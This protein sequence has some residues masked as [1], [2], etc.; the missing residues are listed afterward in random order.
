MD[1]IHAGA[2]AWQVPPTSREGRPLVRGAQAMGVVSFVE[3]F[4]RSVCSIILFSRDLL[5]LV[6]SKLY[7]FAF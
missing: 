6:I 5:P 1:P 4:R 2:D 3:A 7:P